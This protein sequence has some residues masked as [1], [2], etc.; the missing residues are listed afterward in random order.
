MPVA[1]W[2]EG[3]FSAV[4][5]VDPD[6]A[7]L[8]AW[9]QLVD[10][11]PGNDVSQ[12]HAW[13]R[14][15]GMAGFEPLHVFAH[16]EGT[17]VGGA[18]ILF[19]RLPLLGAIGYV[20]Y[21]PVLAVQGPERA[22]VL[23]L[24]GRALT[25]LGRRHLKVLFVQPPEGADDLGPVLLRGGFRPSTAGIAPVGSVRVDLRASEEELRKKLRNRRLRRLA[26][27]RGGEAKGV[28]L[29]IGDAQ[30]VSILVEL[31]GSTAARQGFEPMSADYL[32]TMYQEL[33]QLGHAA[34]FIGEIDG[35]P[36]ASH[37]YTACGDTFKF[38]LT[39]FDRE[40]DVARVG[41]PG[42]LHWEA[43]LWAKDHGYRW[44]DLGGL[45]EASLRA[46]LDG[47]G[48][49]GAIPTHDRFK[50][51]F[52][53]TPYRYPPAVELISSPWVRSVLDLGRHWPVGERLL[54]KAGRALRGGGNRPAP[55]PAAATSRSS[56]PS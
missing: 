47:D 44:F 37:L 36:V 54:A 31:M 10:A 7:A 26:K 24:L 2:D 52:G 1:E 41:V 32:R 4:A 8:R 16:R 29:R 42:V 23:S 11:I 25:D 56:A 40:R 13:S 51:T 21:G 35:V 33:A 9:D 28:R 27:T 12:L 20:S 55:T 46:V 39:G 43:L 6:H 30:D 38:R 5:V 18:Q 50:L 17:L 3:T 14:V 34:L 22:H 45:N 53:G 48:D 19:R 49:R 15:R